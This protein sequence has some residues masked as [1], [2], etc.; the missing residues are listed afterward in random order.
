MMHLVHRLQDSGPASKVPLN[1]LFVDMWANDPV[2]GTLR[3]EVPAQSGTPLQMTTVI[4]MYHD[5]M[6]T[7]VQLDDGELSAWFHVCQE[8]K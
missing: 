2:D 5:S 4:R 6:P 1:M 8:I 7:R 3:R